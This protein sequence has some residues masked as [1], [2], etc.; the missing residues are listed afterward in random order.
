MSLRNQRNSPNKVTTNALDPN[1][2]L[3]VLTLTKTTIH[4]AVNLGRK[5]AIT[6]A[7]YASW[8]KKSE[9]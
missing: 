4:T 3:K 6:T 7:N 2:G 8:E 5:L 1:I 9:R